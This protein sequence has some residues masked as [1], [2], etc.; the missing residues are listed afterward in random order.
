MESYAVIRVS[1]ATGAPGLVAVFD[2]PESAELA[3][4]RKNQVEE[5]D[6]QRIYKFMVVELTN[7]QTFLDR[8]DGKV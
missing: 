2:G 4:Y 5:H 6:H 1:M 7:R 8:I 3:D